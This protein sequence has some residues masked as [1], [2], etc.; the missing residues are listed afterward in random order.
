MA[1]EDRHT[2]QTVS[3]QELPC[4]PSKCSKEVEVEEALAVVEALVVRLR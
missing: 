4:K 2:T 1:A 3:E